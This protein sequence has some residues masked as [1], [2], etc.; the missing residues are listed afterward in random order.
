MAIQVKGL[1]TTIEKIL[2]DES[3]YERTTIYR[4]ISRKYNGI[5]NSVILIDNILEQ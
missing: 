1:E 4:D 3:F 2:N 5:D